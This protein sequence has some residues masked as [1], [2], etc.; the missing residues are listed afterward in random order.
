MYVC[1]YFVFHQ[2]N[3]LVRGTCLD[4]THT[5]L[6]CNFGHHT[7]KLDYA[8]QFENPPYFAKKKKQSVENYLVNGE[9][10][11]ITTFVKM[12]LRLFHV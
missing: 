7:R 2:L 11:L 1:V 10:I 6:M 12:V 4:Q 3:R 8:E 5:K 9:I